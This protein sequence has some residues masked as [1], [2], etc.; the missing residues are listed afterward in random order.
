MTVSVSRR[1]DAN[2]SDAAVDCPR[3]PLPCGVCAGENVRCVSYRDDSALAIKKYFMR[4]LCE[5]C[6]NYT[7]WD[8]ED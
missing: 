5:D 3:G 4:F 8:Y 7:S 6:G 1:R 2:T